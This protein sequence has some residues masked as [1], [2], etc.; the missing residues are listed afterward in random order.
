M[1]AS[2]FPRRKLRENSWRFPAARDQEFHCGQIT[3]Q[4]YDPNDLKH[5]HLKKHM[6]KCQEICHVM[7]LIPIKRS[8]HS[9]LSFSILTSLGAISAEC[10]QRYQSADFWLTSVQQ[11]QQH[12]RNRMIRLLW[13]DFLQCIPSVSQ[14]FS[15]KLTYLN[16]ISAVLH[17][18][19]HY[20][21]IVTRNT[22]HVAWVNAHRR[23][24]M[25]RL[26][27]S[28]FT[29]NAFHNRQHVALGVLRGV[30]GK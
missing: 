26:Q 12:K 5:L 25:I 7:S 14:S 27:V 15:L 9:S 20:T 6:N 18:S 10:T 30:K 4:H 24:L 22:R 21:S 28:A 29:W 3:V 13:H 16:F 17:N 2:G 19:K 23:Y 11:L 1:N 8:H